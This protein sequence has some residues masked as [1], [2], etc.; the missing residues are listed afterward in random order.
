VAGAVLSAPWLA[1][2]RPVPFWK[3]VVEKLLADLW[4][5]ARFAAGLDSGLLSRDPAV[6]AAYDA[7]PMVHRVMTPGAWREIQWAQRV[8][9][10]DAARIEAP[11]LF[12][13]GGADRVV[14]APVTRALAERMRG[15]Q[16]V[17]IH[18]YAEHYHE[19]LHDLESDAVMGDLLAF[20]GKTR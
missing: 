2:A 5:T 19:L 17:E 7:D 10:A 15:R 6:A 18:W 12:L 11:L 20:L 3:R 16:A 8:V 4:P 14:D 1:T 13:L 9:V